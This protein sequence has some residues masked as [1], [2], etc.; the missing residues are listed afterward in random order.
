MSEHDDRLAEL[1]KQTSQETPTAQ[2]DRA[3]LDMAR[4]SV[5]R[6]LYAPFG[7][8]WLVRGATV[9]VMVL[10]VLLVLTLPEQESYLDLQQ[11]V[12]RPSSVDGD[13]KKDS[14]ELDELRIDAVPLKREQP[15][16]K[17]KTEFQFYELLP[18]LEVEAE[19]PAEK[20]RSRVQQAPLADEPVGKSL[21]AP[22]A[23]KKVV[24]HYVQAGSFRDEQ[25]AIDL[26]DRLTGLGYRASVAAV[27]LD[28]GA[29]YY[30]VRVGPYEQEAGAAAAR[31]Q[32]DALGLETRQVL[33]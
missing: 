22:A 15:A 25:R 14:M 23:E 11:D 20:A 16:S 12:Q 10:G 28:D 4:K 31:Q 2:V 26:R 7:A 17:E 13:L 18:E 1:Y 33:K 8:S 21:A 6:K 32:L 5:H 24:S 27:T 29:V 3:V 30:R 19:A 9:G